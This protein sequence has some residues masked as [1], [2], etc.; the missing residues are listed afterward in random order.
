MMHCLEFGDVENEKMSV[1]NR[2]I[3]N[4]PKVWIKLGLRLLLYFGV[5]VAYLTINYYLLYGNLTAL[6]IT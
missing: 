2:K 3:P 4:I 5:T 1:D 6:L